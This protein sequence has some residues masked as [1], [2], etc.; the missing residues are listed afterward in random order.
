M[1]NG[2]PYSA[3]DKLKS[4][5]SGEH[6]WTI[7]TP[8]LN[9]T[10]RRMD[11]GEVQLTSLITAGREWIASPTP[12]FGLLDDTHAGIE[13]QDATGVF[14][15]S[16]YRLRGTLRPT[17]I[18]ASI[19]W[20]VYEE[21]SVVVAEI[22]IVN[23]T[24]HAFEIGNLTSLC[25]NLREDQGQFGALAGGRWDETM[26]PRGYKLETT[27]LDEI[28]RGKSIG[29]AEDGRS[30]GEHVPWFALMH[31]DGGLLAS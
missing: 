27:D 12:M 2:K 29:A 25:L 17:G 13:L 11:A 21:E 7:E 3:L 15:G 10:F 18:T 8:C 30:S 1:Q 6:V 9:L 23:E 31:P 5:S 28:G 4:Q 16:T 24:D 19:A 26:P 20:N 14:E 22:E